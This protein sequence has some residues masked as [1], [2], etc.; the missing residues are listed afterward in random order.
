M[1]YGHDTQTYDLSKG[2]QVDQDIAVFKACGI[3]WVRLAYNGFNNPQSEALAL[4][5]LANGINPILGGDWGTLNS[6]QLVTYD[7]EVLEE[8]QWAQANGIPELGVGN[9]E[10]LRLNGITIAQ[11]AQNLVTLSNQ[12][13]AV[14]SGHVSYSLDAD[15]L[16][17]YE[18]AVPKGTPLILGLNSYDD[19]QGLQAQIQSAIATWG[20]SNVEVTE[21]NCDIPNVP[22]CQTDSGL[23][24][25]VAQDLS[26]LKTM[27]VPYYFFTYR[28]GATAPAYWGVVSD[29]LT[30][31]TIGIN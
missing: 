5:F 28:A 10:E 24:N 16:S 25:Y 21:W 22:Q 27:G 20:A 6:S 31:K 15:Y 12:V 9:E 17:Q 3:R 26:F 7:Q 8:A 23:A 18:A 4:H 14:Y 1:N 19:P 29:P 30:L 2:G 11:W 13:R